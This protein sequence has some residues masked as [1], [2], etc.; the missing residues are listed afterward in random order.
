MTK[1]AYATTNTTYA[2]PF[3]FDTNRVFRMIAD[4]RLYRRTLVEL[5]T[6]NDRE[7]A[8]LGLSRYNLRAVAREAVYGA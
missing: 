5:E 7:L 8:D 3:G 2:R 6:M 1:M 4:W